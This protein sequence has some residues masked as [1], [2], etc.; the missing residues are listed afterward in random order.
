MMNNQNSDSIIRLLAMGN[1]LGSF[2]SVQAELRYVSEC[3]LNKNTKNNI[4]DKD[5]LEG[6]IKELNLKDKESLKNWQQTN[7]LSTDKGTLLL[8]TNVFS[9]YTHLVVFT[10][11]RQTE[12][13]CK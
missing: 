10:S 3:K 6:L 12:S 2:A 7:L 4:S 13:V 8:T 9:F 11:N 1:L 5:A